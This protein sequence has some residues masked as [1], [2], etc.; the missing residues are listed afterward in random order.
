MEKIDYIFGDTLFIGL[1]KFYQEDKG[2]GF[3]C[4]NNW[5]MGENPKFG[6]R[7][8]DFF[9]D[10][11]SCDENVS[12]NQLVVFRP[13]FVNNKLKAINVKPFQKGL[14]FDLAI[15][16]IFG[17]DH[18]QFEEKHRITVR[19]GRSGIRHENVTRQRDISIKAKSGILRYE[20]LEKCCTI[21]NDKGADAFLVG[22][23]TFMSVIGNDRVY[24]EKLLEDFPIKEKEYDTIKNMFS[25]IDRSTIKKL[26]LKHPSFQIGRAHV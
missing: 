20:L 14:H 5:E 18:I 24:Y 4:S 2:F 6:S 25:I 16:Y 9:I 12:T 21:Y 7:Y 23:D 8:N 26:V 11:C 3:I 1:V 10:K 22:I 13:A 15:N 17:D 19:A